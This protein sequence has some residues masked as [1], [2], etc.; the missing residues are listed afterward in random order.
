MTAYPFVRREKAERW[1]DARRAPRKRLTL[2]NQSVPG[3]LSE[4]TLARKHLSTLAAA[5]LDDFAGQNWLPY[6]YGSREFLRVFAFWVD[7]FVLPWCS[8]PKCYTQHT[9]R[10]STNASSRR[11]LIRRVY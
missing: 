7:M 4:E 8:V 1:A 11:S 10:F 5:F 6:A 2:R 9:N 3:V